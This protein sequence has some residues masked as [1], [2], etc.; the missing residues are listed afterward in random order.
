[1]SLLGR[2]LIDCI[3]SI[4]SYFPKNWN[5]GVCYIGLLIHHASNS[6]VAAVFVSG[7]RDGVYRVPAFVM[8][9]MSATVAEVEK[10]LLLMRSHV[11]CWAIAYVFGRDVM[12]WYRL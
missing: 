11:L 3:G 8:P 6:C 10:A 1:V 12:Y 2:S 4:W 9:Y 5:K 7:G